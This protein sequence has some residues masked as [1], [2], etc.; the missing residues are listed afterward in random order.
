MKQLLRKPRPGTRSCSAAP[1]QGERRGD[2]VLGR[3]WVG[4]RGEGSLS[5]GR[6]SGVWRWLE[7]GQLLGEESGQEHSSLGEGGR[8]PAQNGPCCRACRDPHTSPPRLR[9]TWPL[10]LGPQAAETLVTQ[11]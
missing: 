7:S 11:R 4:Q 8:S 6:R 3:G 5:G 9:A 1:R 2:R 10:A